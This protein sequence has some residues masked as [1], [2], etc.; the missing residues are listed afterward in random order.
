VSSNY[1]ETAREV[2]FVKHGMTIHGG[3]LR[4]EAQF[5]TLGTVR[6]IAGPP[7]VS[8]Q[9]AF[10]AIDFANGTSALV[11]CDLLGG[12][13]IFAR[14]GDIGPDLPDDPIESFGPPIS[15]AAFPLPSP[16]G[17][18]APV[19]LRS[20]RPALWTA[21]FS[22]VMPLQGRQRLLPLEGGD[23]VPVKLTNR[24]MLLLRQGDRW[25]T[26]EGLFEPLG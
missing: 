4:E 21:F 16:P 13:Q 11:T 3:S 17:V 25:M 19:R 9:I 5:P 18:V 12:A 26:M 7:A 2:T 20:G 10:A 23:A 8:L 1:G 6:E 15:N 14:S 22:G 24:G